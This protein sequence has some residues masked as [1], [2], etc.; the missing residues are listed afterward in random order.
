MQCA[1]CS[2]DNAVTRCL[3]C[4]AAFY[5]S[6]ECQLFDWQR[7]HRHECWPF[8]GARIIA[9]DWDDTLSVGV[10][11]SERHRVDSDQA[12][13]VAPETR[14]VLRLFAA[15]GVTQVVVSYALQQVIERSVAS[16][17]LPIAAVHTP[18]EFGISHTRRPRL[19]K[20]TMLDI[21]CARAGCQRDQCVL[22]DDSEKNTAEAAAAG[23]RAVRLGPSGG[24]AA[25][26][27]DKPD[28]PARW[29]RF[30]RCNGS[31]LWVLAD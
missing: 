2:R 10:A 7:R 8:A 28:L 4:K 1:G 24:L 5:C 31:L 26:L 6:A 9:Y 17:E 30:V 27:L 15:T 11:K 20:T 23:F 19:R 25:A 22:V 21:I 29:R 16:A 13:H 14:Q 18:E 3:T 12:A